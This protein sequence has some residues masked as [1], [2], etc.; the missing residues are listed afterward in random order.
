[1]DAL[2][3][4]RA[5]GPSATGNGPLQGIKIAVQSVF[6]AADWPTDAG[7]KALENYI[8]PEDATVVKRLCESGAL[9]VGSTRTSEFGFGLTGGNAGKAI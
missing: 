2:W 5:A 1:M 3:Y 4:H 6:S 9:I 7:S 8:A